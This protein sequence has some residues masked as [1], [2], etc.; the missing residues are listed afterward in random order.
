MDITHALTVKN[1][2]PSGV[3]L[4]IN[5]YETGAQYVYYYR[6][7]E[8]SRRRSVDLKLSPEIF[9]KTNQFSQGDGLYSFSVSD[10]LDTSAVVNAYTSH[11]SKADY[12]NRIASYVNKP[13]DSDYLKTVS[14]TASS[15]DIK[16]GVVKVLSDLY[17]GIKDIQDY[18]RRTYAQYIMAAEYY[19]NFAAQTNNQFNAPDISIKY[20]PLM[21]IHF[22]NFITS[23]EIFYFDENNR[24]RLFTIYRPLNGETD[25]T[26]N[27]P[28]GR[29]YHIDLYN[30]G[31]LVCE[32][33]HYQFDDEAYKYLWNKSVD[34]QKLYEQYLNS[35][36]VGADL[37]DISE[38][39]RARLSLEEVR[40]NG[41][42][43]IPRVTIE[44]WVNN[45]SHRILDIKIPHYETLYS[46]NKKFYVVISEPDLFLNGVYVHRYEITSNTVRIYPDAEM[47]DNETIFWIEDENRVIVSD[48][49]RFDMYDAIST[50]TED[51]LV[52]QNRVE[53]NSLV[54]SFFSDYG[55]EPGTIKNAVKS[56]LY[57]L[58]QDTDNSAEDACLKALAYF[59]KSPELSRVYDQMIYY[60][61]TVWFQRFDYT[62]DFFEGKKVKFRNADSLVIFPQ[63]ERGYALSIYR[64]S[65]SEDEE[66][67]S[68]NFESKAGTK[69]NPPTVFVGTN[70]MYLIYAIDQ[71]NYYRSGFI[72]F[73]N[74]EK[75]RQYM[76]DNIEM[77]VITDGR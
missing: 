75:P 39:D 36:T 38:E 50:F 52:V 57:R 11:E 64:I 77:Q 2:N 29:F 70:D 3:T 68:L 22:G 51:Y 4:Y 69:D 6:K 46:M 1:V 72:F 14:E 67:I 25:Y 73:N 13:E 62:T 18:E 45:A 41:D 54:N 30:D 8:P 58:S 15:K 71:N 21:N 28:S 76:L 24:R 63:V 34:E 53:V 16:Y 10:G 74:I 56:I 55:G 19:E 59:M 17:N 31:D 48:F 47:L 66:E 32:Y 23:I 20:T 37:P 12:L 43:F 5:A 9:I 42:A 65:I 35:S 44:G 27:L 40:K 33:S 7:G 60:M 26:V 61:L 49:T